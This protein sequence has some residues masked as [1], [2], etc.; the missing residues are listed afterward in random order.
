MA[1]NAAVPDIT[2]LAQ[3]SIGNLAVADLVLIVYVIGQVV[4]QVIAAIKGQQPPA[5]SEASRAQFAALMG[6]VQNHGQQMTELARQALPPEVTAQLIHVPTR[7][8]QLQQQQQAIIRRVIAA[9]AKPVTATATVGPA[10]APAAAVADGELQ[11]AFGSQPA[12]RGQQPQQT[13]SVAINE[14]GS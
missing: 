5:Q 10:D 11:S 7:L 4:V 2:M 6:V 13:M 1:V 14:G 8:E 3:G 12:P 9:P